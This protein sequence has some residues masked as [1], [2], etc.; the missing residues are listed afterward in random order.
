MKLS[1][2]Y[3][4]SNENERQNN[5]DIPSEIN[6]LKTKYFMLLEIYRFKSDFVE[7]ELPEGIEYPEGT[8]KPK[9]KYLR[10]IL[11]FVK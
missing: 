1:E 6:K 8:K 9:N 11:S 3:G 4:I 2:I 10:I 7:Y 5:M